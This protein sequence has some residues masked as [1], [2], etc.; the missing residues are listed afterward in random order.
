MEATQQNTQYTADD[1]EHGDRNKKSQNWCASKILKHNT[2][3][4]QFQ[5]HKFGENN[6]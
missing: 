6:I 5:T 4:R 2:M 1:D 3:T